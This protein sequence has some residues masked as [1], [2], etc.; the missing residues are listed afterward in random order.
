MR[1]KL[2]E[3]AGRGR[4]DGVRGAGLTSRFFRCGIFDFKPHSEKLVI[5]AC[6]KR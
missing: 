2:K 3:Q 6:Q 5:P 4:G 1:W